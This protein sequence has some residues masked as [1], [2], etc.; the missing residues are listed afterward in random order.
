MTRRSR[1]SS[2]GPVAAGFDQAAANYDTTGTE[3]FVPLG[4]RLVRH[5]GIAAG[6]RVADLG[7]GAGAAL[8][9]A[10]AA[11]GPGGQATGIDAS[12]DMLTRARQAAR[13][14]G[15][16]VTLTRGDARDPRL[17]EASLDVIT[18]SSVLQFL[19]M[20]RRAV[21]TWLRLLAPGGRIAVSWGMRQDPRWVP[22]MACLDQAVPPPAPGF[23][24][25]LRR[26][27]FDSAAGVEQMFAEAGYARTATWPEPFTT[28]YTSPE[29]WWT[30]CQS[31]APWIVSWRHIPPARLAKARDLALDHVDSLRDG[32][33]LI[34]R[35]LTFGC[36][37]A[38]RPA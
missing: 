22:V 3:F 32:D 17:P 25:Y 13:D 27:P 35:T 12:A 37:V 6:E 30:A 8:L 36:T 5:A 18:A 33:G 19:D 38:F 29:Q 15:L 4:A 20:P 28:A 24:E 9:P 16:A 1:L 7:C 23:E 34:R 2:P 14:R 21:R 26:P 11:A 31:Q 10:A